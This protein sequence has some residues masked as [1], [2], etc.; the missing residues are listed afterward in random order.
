MTDTKEF[1]IK[2][3]KAIKSDRTIMLSVEGQD[4]A[5]PMTAMLDGEQ[6]PIWIF[7]AS[8]SEI[9]KGLPAANKAMG[10]FAS[11]GHDLFAC[12]AG[13][14]TLSNDRAMIDRLWNPFIAAWYEGKDDPNLA[15]L[16][17]DT[18]EARIWKDASSLIAG[19][20]VLLGA[21]P[22]KDYSDKVADVNLG[23]AA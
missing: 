20:K 18:A 9:V 17:F 2:L 15:L 10:H 13:N 11:K 14:L 3:W 16:R 21:D 23:K 19:I 12:I 4:H 1:E 6:G 22:K 8:D 5:R 7:T